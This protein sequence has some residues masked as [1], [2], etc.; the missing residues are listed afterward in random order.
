MSV[1]IIR[2]RYPATCVGCGTALLRD[3]RAIRDTETKAITCVTCAP[4]SD[5]EIDRGT[6]GAS[7]ARE[8]RR[9]HDRRER[10]VRDRYGKL[11]GVV[12]ALTDDPQT[13]TAWVAGANGESG[14]GAQ[15]DRLRDEGI[16]VIHDRR[17]PRS[18][19]NVDHIVVAPSGVF[20]VDAKNY[21]GR[22][23]VVDRGG[24]FAHDQRLYV[25]RRD[26][27]KLVA[28]LAPQ[29]AAVR[30]ALGAEHADVPVWRALCFVS[31]DFD[32]FACTL[33]VE[34]AYVVAPRALGKL[35]RTEGRLDRAS[36][37]RI[38]GRLALALPPA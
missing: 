35:L 9:R 18:R 3:T 10:E 37:E 32:L 29:A 6:A 22:V 33:V 34:G 12:L 23:R 13:T 27:T 31:A 38:E 20:V 21:R 25:G 19:A 8:W 24:F 11:G 1:G 26:Q 2:L 28:G 16:A 15:L 14:L 5:V 4:R 36:I 17:L 30:A 7:A